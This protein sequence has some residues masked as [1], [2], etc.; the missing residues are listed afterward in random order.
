M[1]GVVKAIAVLVAEEGQAAEIPGFIH[2]ARQAIAGEV[3]VHAVIVGTAPTE[4]HA[5]EVMKA[6]AASVVLVSHP[7]LALPVHAD[8]LLTVLTPVLPPMAADV[9]LLHADS[10]G[11]E[12]AARL[13][14][15]MGG[16][17]LGRCAGLERS[18]TSWI[19]RKP[20]YGGRMEAVLEAGPGL[21]FAV[22]HAIA[23]QDRAA[24][25]ATDAVVQRMAFSSALPSVDHIRHVSLTGQRKRV[26]GARIVVCGG[27]GMGG[28]EGF[29]QLQ[30]LAD[31][32]GA[33]VGG[34]LPAVDAGWVPVSHQIGQ[35]G[36]YVAPAIYVAVGLSGTPQ[37]LAGVA[38]RTDIIAINRDE[39]AEIFRVARAGV[40]ADWKELLP[41]LIG[42]F[43]QG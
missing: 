4:Q 5:D 15:R 7:Q 25:P 35:S 33:A 9:V 32:L 14:M 16:T 26:E 34:S 41:V 20:A 13:A 43:R 21:C 28:P 36:K 40:V 23:S 24:S 3:N 6:G 38:P 11:D 12:V 17:A 29:A 37:H 42:K 18:A 22:L 39:E 2:A 31:K 27:R 10:V 19:A 1:T 8:Q 30:A